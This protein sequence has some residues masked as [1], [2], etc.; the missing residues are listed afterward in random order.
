MHSPT[1]TEIEIEVEVEVQI[2]V[3]V[4]AVSAGTLHCLGYVVPNAGS[5]SGRRGGP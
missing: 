2:D 4:E 1:E 3:E 5:G